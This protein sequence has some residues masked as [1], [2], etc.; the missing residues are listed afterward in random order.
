MSN[1][2]TNL[3]GRL[4]RTQ[5]RCILP[6]LL[7]PLGITLALLVLGG[8]AALWRQHEE[9]LDL[10]V[11]QKQSTVLN[12]FHQ[13]LKIR[14]EALTTV[15][16][17]ISLDHRL[18]KALSSSDRESLLKD[19]QSLYDTLKKEGRLSRFS[20]FDRRRLCLLR[21]HDPE[22]RGDY[23][24]HSTLL[25]VEHSG[26]NA[27]GIEIGPDNS[28]I[29]R[30]VQPVTL[31][32]ELVGYVE[33]GKDIKDELSALHQRY[34]AH[35]A[36]GLG[37][38]YLDWNSWEQEMRHIGRSN[39]WKRL[40]HHVIVYASQGSLP[41]AFLFLFNLIPGEEDG[42]GK[43]SREIVS[44]GKTWRA[45]LEP[46][47]DAAGR[48]IGHLL[49][50]NDV[51]EDRAAFRRLFTLGG[52]ACVVLL[53]M[54][55][56]FVYALLRR[57][58]SGILAQRAALFEKSA[59]L[60][61]FFTLSLDL[62]CIL[63]ADLRFLRLSP[64]WEKV[65][66]YSL[67]ELQGR[68]FLDLV[69]ADDLPG[70]R[71]LLS[72]LEA[73]ETVFSFES[74]C[75]CLDGSCRW[76]EWRLRRSGALVYVAARDVTE[77][78]RIETEMRNW[79]L[80]LEEAIGR[81][82]QM[83]VQ[84]E[85][86]CAAKSEFLAN[87]SHEI[88]T[89]MNGVIGMLTLLGETELNA[90]QREY[91]EGAYLS[92]RALLQIIN[93]ILDF[94]KIEAGKLVLN[95]APFALRELP[96]G[97]EAMLRPLMVEKGLEFVAH[98]DEGV[99]E[100]CVGDMDRLRQ[101][102]LNLIGNSIKF[103]GKGGGIILLVEVKER[104][105]EHLVLQFNICDSGIGIAKD[106]QALIFEAFTQADMSTTKQ[107][108]GTGLGLTIS[109][110]LVEMMGGEIGVKSE[111][112]RG[113]HFYFTVRL[114]IAAEAVQAP[115]LQ[116]RSPDHKPGQALRILLAEDNPINQKFALK[117]LEKAG[118]LVKIAENGAQAVKL[119]DAKE[120]DVVLLDVQMPGMGGE[121]AMD[122]MRSMPG[123]ERIPIVALTAHALSGDREK[124]LERGFDG[125]VPK[126]FDRGTLLS[127]LADLC[128]RAGSN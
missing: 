86:A 22:R 77:R 118:H 111:P 20:F 68:V 35:L 83:A 81:A 116:D 18:Q 108:G 39:E 117:I 128:Q 4:E 59:E 71:D 90:E 57:V 19:W 5:P 9:R 15:L 85:I 101:V 76:I 58:D 23:I 74:R 99:P 56:G 43:S 73:Q 95:Q 70:I 45:L 44:Q 51:T 10:I 13:Q 7:P 114:G 97:V 63:D 54:L 37:K 96:T 102:L 122:R 16:Q 104:T 14:T 61:R 78:K 21:F 42:H 38:D 53:T 1:V 64:E 103:T 2:E 123:G 34:G 107:F 113:S 46:V 48:G 109:K 12:G 127:L 28:L 6:R 62:L 100:Q 11:N 124:Y 125:Y 105:A 3:T 41:E 30:I 89:P 67:A 25:K 32:G 98:I 49:V 47:H 79:N 84:A 82:N 106:K 29:L 69:H 112:G 17:F 110:R 75:S 8:G 33:F 91:A 94:S 92:S 88:R 50:A 36:L 115:R 119:F 121:E 55:L 80:Q 24:D 52:A 31:A 27:S 66:G 93:D 26:Q 60:D 120:F 72:K 40:P 65:L 87:M 126:P